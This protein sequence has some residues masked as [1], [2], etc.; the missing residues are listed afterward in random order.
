[1]TF[2]YLW[3]I[4]M[5]GGFLAWS[6]R[7]EAKNN[8]G[9]FL[10]YKVK[11]KSLSGHKSWFYRNFMSGGIN[12]S[13]PTNPKDNAEHAGMAF[14]RDKVAYILNQ[15]IFKCFILFCYIFY[16]VGAVWG[17]F[18]IQEGL[19]KRNTANRDS[20]SVQYYNMDDEYFKEYAYTINVIIHGPNIDFSKPEVQK[21]VENIVKAL[22]DS[23][24]I[25]G[26][27]T[28]NW[29]ANFLDY[30]DRNKGFNDVNL[31]VDTAEEFA[32]T[33]KNIYLADPNNPERLDVS[34]SD[35]G[36]R[37]KAARFIIQVIFNHSNLPTLPKIIALL[38]TG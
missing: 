14:F 33:L 8:H 38:K 31:P 36:T 16:I 26:N 21:R 17:C 28:Q 10:C 6:G 20:Y 37:V 25:D 13:D 15:N 11:P 3:H 34:F 35:D 12:P 2:T 18:A 19:D 30:V 32:D 5:F 22:E 23:Q 27:S 29:L 9:C 4:T 1:M 24:Y 7:S